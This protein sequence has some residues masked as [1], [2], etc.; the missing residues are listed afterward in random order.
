[1]IHPH[2]ASAEAR[3]DRK[4]AR[5]LRSSFAVEQVTGAPLVIAEALWWWPSVTTLASLHSGHDV[6]YFLRERG[7]GGCVG[8]MSYYTACGEPPGVWAGA[9]AERLGLTGLAG[10]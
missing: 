9:G 7:V 4:S 2:Y 1:M 3:R 6:A 8:A 10:T 5:S